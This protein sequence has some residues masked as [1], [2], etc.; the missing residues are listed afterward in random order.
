MSLSPQQIEAYH[1]DGVLPLGRVL[2]A[3]LVEEARAHLEKLRTENQ[4]DMPADERD[5]KMYRLLNTSSKDPWFDC[6]I[7]HPAVLDAAAAILGPKVQYFQDNVFYKPART[8]SAT[9]WHQDNIWW[10]ANP[11]HM[12][13]IW[14]A[15][16]DVDPGN[17]GVR[18]VPGSQAQLISPEKPHKDVNGSEYNMMSTEQLAQIDRMEFVTFNV[19]AGHAVMHHCQTLHG[20][21][22]NNS[23][24][25]RRGYT[26]HLAQPGCIQL[27]P[28]KNPILRG[29]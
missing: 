13:T 15:L 6:I 18:Y 16:D 11:P 7:R 2:E 27:D 21:P 20:A 28:V 25:I 29:N 8:G 5:R 23:E 3:A 17:G 10:N 12:L 4:M 19:P 14:I 1:R 22:P 26:V 24:R 9:P